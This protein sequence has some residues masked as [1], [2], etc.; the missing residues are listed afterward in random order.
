MNDISK[1]ILNELNSKTQSLVKLLNNE[2]EPTDKSFNILDLL[3]KIED[4]KSTIIQ[5]CSNQFD[6]ECK[7]IKAVP[8]TT[9]PNSNL[10]PV[11]DK[12]QPLYSCPID[13]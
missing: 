7:E 6:L 5:N 9:F 3:Q 12:V 10:P 13:N 2:I 1:Q 8:T 11:T 4:L